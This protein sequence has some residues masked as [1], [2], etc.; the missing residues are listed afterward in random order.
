MELLS[1]SS[2]DELFATPSP[3]AFVRDTRGGLVVPNQWGCYTATPPLTLLR[4][5]P[6]MTATSGVR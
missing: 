1:G 5:R 4:R 3:L 6:A 2:D